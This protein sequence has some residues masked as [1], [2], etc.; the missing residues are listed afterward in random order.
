MWRENAAVPLRATGMCTSPPPP[1]KKPAERWLHTCAGAVRGL[2]LLHSCPYSP[3]VPLHAGTYLPN[4][5]TAAVG[6][7]LTGVPF[8]SQKFLVCGIPPC[9]SYSIPACAFRGMRWTEK[10]VTPCTL[11]AWACLTLSGYNFSCQST[12][13]DTNSKKIYTLR[14]FLKEYILKK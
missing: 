1:P 8:P 4:G 12:N 13:I 10:I 7:V 6:Q 2:H 5:D 11:R 3:T 9:L 14:Y